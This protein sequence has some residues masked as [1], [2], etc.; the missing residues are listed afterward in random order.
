MPSR[1]G[2]R[3]FPPLQLPPSAGPRQTRQV[4]ISNCVGSRASTRK[5]AGVV[6]VRP[7]PPTSASVTTGEVPNESGVQGLCCEQR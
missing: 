3:A 1:K 5:G 4:P 2:L 7:S 6:M